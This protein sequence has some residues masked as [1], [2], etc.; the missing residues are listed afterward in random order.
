M[1][2]LRPQQHVLCAGV[3]SHAY[4][5]EIAVLLQLQLRAGDMEL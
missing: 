3:A 4:I 2:D 5:V 1:D